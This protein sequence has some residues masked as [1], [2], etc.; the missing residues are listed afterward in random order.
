MT[1]QWLDTVVDFRSLHLIGFLPDVAVG[2]LPDV[3]F[4]P[5][6]FLT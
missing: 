3:A 5:L 1:A 4:H 2:V 6:S